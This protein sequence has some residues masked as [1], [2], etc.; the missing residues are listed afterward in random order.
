MKSILLIILLNFLSYNSDLSK[1]R[2]LYLN[3]SRSES[4]CDQLG[5]KLNTLDVKSSVLLKGYK[6][7]FY[8]IKCKFINSPSKKLIFFNKGKRLIESAIKEDPTSVELK[9]LR[10]SIQ[11]NLPKF[12]L[13]NKNIE[14]DLNFVNENIASVKNKES[15]KFIITSLKSLNK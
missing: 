10:F 15:Q 3:A 6:G 2:E 8:F 13:Y 9:F 14:K 4:N 5:A 7:C 1:I 11:K 12:L